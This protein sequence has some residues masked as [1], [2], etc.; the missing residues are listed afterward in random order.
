MSVPNASGV[1]ED[2]VLHW[3]RY[4][5]MPA[6]LRRVYQLAPFNMHMGRARQRLEV[7]AKAGADAAKM[8]T[9]EIFLICRQLQD[10]CRETYG[11]DHP[12]AGRSRLGQRMRRSPTGGRSQ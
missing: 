10:R 2:R 12:D 3:A 1:Y 6:E 8:R 7:Y 4:D 5:G 9:A 11:E